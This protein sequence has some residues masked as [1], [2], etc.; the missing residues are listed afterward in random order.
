[1]IGD[2]TET[3]GAVL[4][5]SGS[6]SASYT[7]VLIQPSGGAAR[8]ISGDLEG[9]ALLALNGADNVTIDGLNSGGNALTLSNIDNNLVARGT[10][11]LKFYGGASNNTITNATLL[12]SAIGRDLRFGATVWF[13]GTDTT[14]G[15]DDNVISHC[16]IGPAG[17]NVPSD[18]ILVNSSGFGLS[19]DNN[20]IDG[21]NIYD[22]FDGFGPSHGIYLFG[23]SRAWT[24]SNNR[25]YQTAPRTQSNGN[26]HAAIQ[27]DS[28]G[29]NDG[30]IISNNTIG[31]ASAAG[32]GTYNLTFVGLGTGQFYGIYYTRMG[33]GATTT[34][35]GNTITLSLD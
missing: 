24:I 33:G 17:A 20:V 18:A 14:T 23:I 16:N 35:Q 3:A 27:V 28:L 29:G 13:E 25:F 22:Y 30:H 1:V 31:Y 21:N 12:G 8:T 5:A 6:G 32:T 19:G 7:S 9:Q 10:A 4:N 26:L 34:I 11:T 2:T 15:N